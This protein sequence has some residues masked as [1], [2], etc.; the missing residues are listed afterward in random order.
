MIACSKKGVSALQLQRMLGLGSYKTAWHLAHR[1]RRAM[2]PSSKDPLLSGT[3]EVDETLVGGKH[4]GKG[5]EYAYAKK[6]PLVAMVAREGQARTKVVS[7]VSA[8]TLRRAIEQHV[9]PGGVL[10]TDELAGYQKIAARHGRH[11]TVKH[12]AKEYVR[13]K[14]HTN[15][16]E[17]FFALF[18]R[19]V[20]GSFHHVSRKHLHRYGDEFAFRWTHRKVEDWQRASLLLSQGLRRQTIALAELTNGHRTPSRRFTLPTG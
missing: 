15:T 8:T 14:A 9:R 20:H 12:S 4:T 16:V 17:S 3:V 11:V 10:M 5:C 1:L 6:T 2:S 19:G 18:K 7:T 13:G